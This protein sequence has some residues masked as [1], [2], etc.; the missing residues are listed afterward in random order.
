MFHWICPEC[1]H[2]IPP[3]V[4]ECEYCHPQAVEPVAVAPT[5]VPSPLPV[6]VLGQEALPAPSGP[7]PL[8]VADIPRSEE[9][10]Q[11]QVVDLLPV[12]SPSVDAVPFG[13]TALPPVLPASNVPPALPSLFEQNAVEAQPVPKLSVSAPPIHEIA[14]PPAVPVAEVA[15]EPE[16]PAV[17]VETTPQV[18]EAAAVPEPP[19]AVTVP[20]PVHEIAQPPAPPVVE[21]ASEPEPP[22]AV[23][24]PPVVEVASEPERPAAVAAPPLV[25]EIAQPS[26]PPVVEAA[27]EA[28]PPATASVPPVVHQDTQLP[29]VESA[30][31]PE[32]RAAISVRPVIYEIA[33]PPPPP[34]AV[35]AP[36]VT[37][38]AIERE[39][40]QPPAPPATVEAFAVSEPV[41]E[42]ASLE[43]SEAPAPD[44]LP[45]PLLAMAQQIR[46]AQAG[47]ASVAPEPELTGLAELAEAINEHRPSPEASPSTIPAPEIQPA[48]LLVPHQETPAQEPQPVAQADEPHYSTLRL[49]VAV[50]AEPAPSAVALAA[51]ES[52]SV[53]EAPVPVTEAPAEEGPVLPLAP[54]QKHGDATRRSIRPV[55]PTGKV[56]GADTEPRL[57]LPGPA[58]PPELARLQDASPVTKI[59]GNVELPT[60]A[61]AKTAESAAGLQ[62]WLL[63]GLVA[64]VLTSIALSVVYF[65]LLPRT[66]ADAKPPVPAEAAPPTAA[67]A[68]SGNPVAKFV[69]VTG[70]RIVADGSKK[71]EVQYLVVN[72]SDADISDASVLVTLRGTKPGQAPVCRFSFKVPSLGPFE[73][74]EMSS[75]IEKT[76]SLILPDWQDL[77]ADVQIS[78]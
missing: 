37:V 72:H 14:Q 57:T 9:A 41:P 17:V 52:A 64:L 13:E 75:P 31:E 16:P 59:G 22:A 44:E 40:L 26:A 27:A 45:D 48:A 5:P 10:K 49:P 23:T 51:P 61:K 71:S 33:L 74:K 7:P 18:V 29:V 4:R 36:A 35:E 63:S 2:E 1:G 19:V 67:P 46:S 55:P 76:R 43:K 39:I 66:V 77:R 56:L 21:A 69:E 58:L 34:A 65:L 8:P 38:P 28:E 78:Q 42:K 53:I 15:V 25:P 12:A 62:G 6:Q 20:P 3:S 11:P 24:E 54:I 60:A 30:S 32:P 50:E 47:Q 68:K 70:F 73:S